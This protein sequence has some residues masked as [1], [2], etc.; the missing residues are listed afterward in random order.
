MKTQ[1]G[2]GERNPPRSLAQGQ[3]RAP[4]EPKQCSLLRLNSLKLEL[5]VS[6]AQGMI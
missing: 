6:T 1:S 5:T 4:K 2:V 3:A